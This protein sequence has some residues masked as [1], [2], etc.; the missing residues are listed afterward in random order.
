MEALMRA[1]IATSIG[2]AISVQAGAALQPRDLTGDNVV[3]A[4]YETVYGQTW[5]STPSIFVGNPLFLQPAYQ[6]LQDTYGSA[7]G[8][9]RLPRVLDLNVDLSDCGWDWG[10]PQ[11]WCHRSS[12]PDSSELSRLTSLY[13][14]LPFTPLSSWADNTVK[15]APD[16]ITTTLWAI[17]GPV[18]EWFWADYYGENAQFWFLHDGDIGQPIPEPGTWALTAAGLLALVWRYRRRV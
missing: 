14:G 10:S 17:L 8:T 18:D 2:L 3:D 13:S 1:A 6:E 9:W 4:Y 16:G 15:V 5:L 11:V 7:Q 12:T